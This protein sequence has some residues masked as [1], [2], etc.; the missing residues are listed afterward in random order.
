MISE[1]WM[2]NIQS[3]LKPRQEMNMGNVFSA[4]TSPSLRRILPTLVVTAHVTAE[5][6]RW[7][8][9][10]LICWLFNKQPRENP[11]KTWCFFCKRHLQT[12]KLNLPPF[13]IS[14]SKRTCAHFL[15]FRGQ[16]E[17]VPISDLPGV[18]WTCLLS[19]KNHTRDW[20]VFL[21]EKH[22]SNEKRAPG[23]LG[24]SWGWDPTQLY[25]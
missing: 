21:A 16:K 20:D 24:Y 13:G 2:V 3:T 1:W 6:E 11:K 19:G 9:T 15:E 17:L 23:C 12:W 7:I 22:L 4:M 14:R 25:I 8:E 10:A 18:Q 5:N